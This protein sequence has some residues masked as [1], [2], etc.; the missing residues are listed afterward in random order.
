[1]F[2][3][4]YINKLISSKRKK[5][6][7]KLPPSQIDYNNPNNILSRIDNKI[8]IKDHP[9]P[10]IYCYHKILKDEEKVN[11]ICKKCNQDYHINIPTFL[12]TSCNYNFCQKCF[13]QYKVKDITLLSLDKKENICNQEHNL[14]LIQINNIYKECCNCGNGENEYCKCC[15]LCNYILCPNCMNNK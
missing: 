11:W 14:M 15:S 2:N 10:L 9:H 12:C 5:T 6:W 8:L 1:M 4:N 7:L 13:L 3:E